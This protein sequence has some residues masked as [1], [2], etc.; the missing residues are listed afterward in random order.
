MEKIKIKSVSMTNF[1]KL[2]ESY[3][4]MA[5]KASSP[6]VETAPPDRISE[7]YFSSFAPEALCGIDDPCATVA[8]EIGRK[9]PSFRASFRGPFKT[10]GEALC[11]ALE[12][13]LPPG[14][15]VLIL[16]CEK[17]THMDASEAALHLSNRVNPHDR[18]YGATL[19]A[20]GA[21]VTRYYM[22]HYRVPY[23]AFHAVSVKNHRNALLNPRAQFHREIH[24]R[25]VAKSPIV[26][27]PLRRLHCAPITDGAVAVLLSRDEGD[28]FFRGWARGRDTNLFQERKD[29]G[30]F[31]ATSDASQKALAQSGTAPWEADVVEIHDAF[32][33]FELINLE[34]M[35]FYAMGD[36]WKALNDGELDI[37]GRIAVNPSGGLKGRGHPI[38]A[39]G[40]SSVVEVHEQ[41]THTAGS[42]QHD[43]ARLAMIQS[44][45]GVSNESY[46][47]IIDTAG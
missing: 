26:S 14:R 13:G 17:M 3:A 27:D 38:G 34:E 15:E 2:D 24:E 23:R 42:R 36:A 39:C 9:Y 5:L 25:M 35:G 31:L 28:T 4:S 45:G 8:Q 32:S 19:P 20:L 21:L 33:P 10:G 41:L 29:I 46:V 22:S 37:N 44:A 11:S 1:G 16:A 7:V 18:A 30:R 12:N 6:I 47:F 43:P 40:L